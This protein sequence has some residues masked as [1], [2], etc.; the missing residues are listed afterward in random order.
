M[1]ADA[2]DVAIVGA[3]VIG[4]ACAARL[5]RDGRSVVVLERHDGVGQETSSRNSGVIHAG[6]YYPPG[7]LKALCCVEGRQ[8]LYERCRRDGVPHG[9]CGKLVVA[10]DDA[11]CEKLEDIQRRGLDNGAGQLELLDRGQV[12]RMEPRVRAVAGLLSPETGIVDVHGLMDSYKAEATAR[13]AELVLVTQVLELAVRGGGWQVRTESRQGERFELNAGAVVNAAGLSAHEVASRAGLDIDA[14]GYRQGFCKGDYF[15]LGSRMR[16]AVKR[17]I[18]PV[19]PSAGLGIHLT[20]DLGG[21]LMAGP[22]TEW[23]DEIGY[24]VR[25]EKR[26]LFA[27]AVRRY[28]PELRDDDLDPDYAGVRPKLQLQGGPPRDFLIE[29]GS[30]HGAPGLVNLIGIESPGLTSSEAIANRVAALIQ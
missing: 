1:S 25:E 26:A 14:L 18:Y 19:P 17:L 29:E 22:D 21:K 8:L 27:E 2:V 13:G 11:E 5:S 23:I 16:G 10:T 24:E 9:N 28:L 30:P 6:L 7:S 4:L 12:Q 3:G 20:M 15:V